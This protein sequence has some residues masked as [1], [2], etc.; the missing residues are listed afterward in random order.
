MQITTSLILQV[1]REL[2]ANP[3]MHYVNLLQLTLRIRSKVEGESSPTPEEFLQYVLQNSTPDVAK[4]L[5][6][7]SGILVETPTQERDSQGFKISF[8]AIMNSF[9][10]QRWH[11]SD[12][13]DLPPTYGLPRIILTFEVWDIVVNLHHFHTQMLAPPI[14]HFLPQ[15]VS[16]RMVTPVISKTFH[17]RCLTKGQNPRLKR[18]V[19]SP[20]LV[21]CFWRKM[22][23]FAILLKQDPGNSIARCIKK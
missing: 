3:G 10:V 6:D 19:L 20:G 15:V 2:G 1:A 22:R 11:S 12:P 21:S 4:Q 9:R 17:L 5:F 16:A 13:G 14:R 7:A 23:R 18:I 8:G